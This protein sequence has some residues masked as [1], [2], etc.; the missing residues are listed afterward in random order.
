MKVRP[1]RTLNA[2]QWRGDNQKEVKEVMGT[3]AYVLWLKGDSLFIENMEECGMDEEVGVGD[4][5]TV[6]Q[7]GEIG[8]DTPEEFEKRYIKVEE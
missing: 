7:C 4:W 1:R 5:I 2:V 8:V 6:G 3:C